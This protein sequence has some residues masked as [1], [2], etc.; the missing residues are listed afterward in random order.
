MPWGF[1]LIVLTALLAVFAVGIEALVERRRPSS[2]A[3]AGLFAAT[4]AG[5]AAVVERV[6]FSGLGS[7]PHAV[8][9]SVA[10]E[11]AVASVQAC[12]FV[13][14][15]SV[16]SDADRCEARPSAA[17]FPGRGAPDLLLPTSAGEMP[18]AETAGGADARGDDNGD[19]VAGRDAAGI[20]D[21]AEV[22]A[23]GDAHRRR[24]DEPAAVRRVSFGGRVWK[25]PT[26]EHPLLTDGDSLL[27][28][29]ESSPRGLL[30]SAMLRDAGGRVIGRLERNEWLHNAHGAFDRNFTADAVEVVDRDGTVV[31]QAVRSGGVVSVEGV[32][33]CRNGTTLQLMHGATPAQAVFAVSPANLPP[34]LSIPPLCAYPSAQ[35]LGDCPGIGGHKRLLDWYRPVS[36]AGIDEPEIRRWTGALDLCGGGP[37]VAM[38]TRR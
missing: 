36:A 9:S 16:R 31:F 38:S 27:L 33:Q 15:A 29:V 22:G 2:I 19:S 30:V 18:R 5:G 21:D 25:V 8:A 20:R 17:L 35:R 26:I 4:L 7:Q 11:D 6:S 24:S 14:A 34:M 1:V 13:P 37:S 28:Q 32:F 10:E 3:L 12:S 23:P